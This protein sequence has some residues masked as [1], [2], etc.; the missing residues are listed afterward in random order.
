MLVSLKNAGIF[1]SKK[2]LVRGVSMTVEAGEIVTLI[3]PNGSR[4]STSARLALGVRSV[5]E[6]H[7]SRKDGLCVS[8]VPQK[9]QL[10]PHLPLSV[11]RFLRLTFR[12]DRKA[13]NLAFKATGTDH[14]AD[15]QMAS[16]SGGEFQRVLLARAMAGALFCCR[17]HRLLYIHMS[18][19]ISQH[20]LFWLSLIRLQGRV[21]SCPVRDKI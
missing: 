4:K 10:S 9:I 7:A 14:L 18:S 12:P 8:Y 15:E 21:I 17:L 2:W 11:T 5:D 19:P 20:R 1:R 13:I 6:G 16:L 3:G